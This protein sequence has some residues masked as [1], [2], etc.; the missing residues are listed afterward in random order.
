MDYITLPGFLFSFFF[1]KE[2]KLPAGIKLWHFNNKIF[3]TFDL[4]IYIKKNN[5]EKLF[6]KIHS[7]DNDLAEV[8][9]YN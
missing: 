3:V 8:I 2:G 5:I 6:D 1:E 4:D 9:N 7:Y